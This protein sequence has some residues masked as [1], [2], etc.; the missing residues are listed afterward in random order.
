MYVIV[1]FIKSDRE[2]RLLVIDAMNILR[3]LWLMKKI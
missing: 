3:M 1:I 2:E